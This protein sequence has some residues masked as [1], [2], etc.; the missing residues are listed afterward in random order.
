MEYATQADFEAVLSE[1]HNIQYVDAI[2][3]DLCGYV[4][5]KRFPLLEADKIFSDGVLLPFSAFYL[6]V[7]GGVTNTL[8]L[9]FTDGD[10]DGVLMPV[11]NTIKPVPW[12][13]RILQVLIS[14]RKEQEKWGVIKDPSEVDP[15]NMLKKILKKFRGS[16][17][18][19]V[20]AFELEFYLLDK[21][22][23]KDGKPIPA[24]GA[25][26]T[27][28]YGIPDLDIF[29]DLFHDINENC[30]KQDIPAT[31][32]SS[33]FAAGQYE[34][35][36]RHT[37]DLLKA[38]DDAALLRRVIKETCSRHGYEATFMAKPFLEE[39]GNGMHLH[40]SVYD[41][42]DENIFATSNRYGNDYLKNAI[43]GLQSTFY[44]S[45]PIFIPNRNGYRRIQT[46]NFVPVN[47]SWSWNRR[48]V[49]LRIPA[50]SAKARRIEHRAASADANPYLVLACILAGLHHGL[51]NKLKPNNLVN[52]DNTVGA[53]KE[54][55]KNMPTSLESSLNKFQDS[56]LLLKYLGKEYLKLY[57][58]TKLGEIEH[59]SSSFIPKEE[60]DFYL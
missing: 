35:N 33:E 30:K 47:T 41:N 57:T 23:D 60:Y 13:E 27:H 11:K 34:I 1:H 37:G 12:D 7:L 32:A 15:R 31:T 49:S 58:S 4:R 2:F 9:G 42:N 22:R 50:G 54:A 6:D 59:M 53:D 48:D 52:F 20:V 55:D 16:G 17:F 43:A 51:I 3:T 38:A 14:F 40:I 36:L 18:N 5:G 46:R 56:L 8:N 10:P 26:K 28:V 21:E 19:P 45:F 25:N 44:D 29:G 24:Q 39:T